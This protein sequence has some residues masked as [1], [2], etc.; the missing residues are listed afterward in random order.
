[1]GVHFRL[2]AL[3][4]A[5]SVWPGTRGVATVVL[6]DTVS[7]CPQLA[8]GARWSKRGRFSGVDRTKRWIWGLKWGAG[9]VGRICIELLLRIDIDAPGGER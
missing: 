5:R 4:T 8:G 2:R 7:I 3:P 9:L 1:M 6:M